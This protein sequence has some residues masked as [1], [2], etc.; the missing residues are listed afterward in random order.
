MI[1]ILDELKHQGIE[2]RAV[3]DRIQAKPVEKLTGEIVERIR[4]NKAAILEHLR[5]RKVGAGAPRDTT[6]GQSREL[7]ES[8]NDFSRCA[9]RTTTGRAGMIQLGPGR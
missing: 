9:S 3:G 2:L 7:I 5:A 8:W 6:G 4:R 1:A